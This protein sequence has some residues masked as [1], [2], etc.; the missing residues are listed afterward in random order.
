MIGA[1]IGGEPL[2]AGELNRLELEIA[3]TAEIQRI[4]GSALGGCAV[5]DECLRLSCIEMLM[6][7]GWQRPARGRGAS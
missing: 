7:G 4:S 1:S 5:G 2:L 6:L 3:M